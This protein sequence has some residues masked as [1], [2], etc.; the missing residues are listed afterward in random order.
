MYTI[1]ILEED[2]RMYLATIPV[3]PLHW[4]AMCVFSFHIFL[5]KYFLFASILVVV[6]VI[7]FYQMNW[8]T[9]RNGIE[10]NRSGSERAS[11]MNSSIHLHIN[12]F[13]A[14]KMRERERQP[15][16]IM[17]IILEIFSL[18]VVFVFTART[19][20]YY[21]CS[22]VLLLLLLLF[23]YFIFAPHRKKIEFSKKKTRSRLFNSVR[24]G[25]DRLQKNPSIRAE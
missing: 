8:Q 2:V 3:I 24:I 6:I 13:G 20:A 16:K 9:T 12:I 19:L 15:N 22:V 10:I 17:I 4:C 11:E 25:I 1:H 14:I 18:F 5:V 23:Q 21:F 7:L